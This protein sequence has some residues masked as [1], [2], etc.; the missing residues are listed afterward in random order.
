VT[1]Y[2]GTCSVHFTTLDGWV[3][4]QHR[5]PVSGFERVTNSAIA[6]AEADIYP[7]KWMRPREPQD[8]A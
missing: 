6:L 4:H 8:A 2:C 5:R 7:H 3:E 1:G